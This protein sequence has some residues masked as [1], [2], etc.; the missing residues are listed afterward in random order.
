MR[1]SFPR[2]LREVS[3]ATRMPV[4]EPVIRMETPITSLLAR[5]RTGDSRALEELTPR[6]Y[7]ELRRLASARFRRE[8]EGHTL[9]PTAL[10]HEAFLRLCGDGNEINWQSRAH[11]LGIAARVMRQVLIQHAR[12]RKAEKRGSGRVM[13]S[14]D[15]VAVASAAAS[16]GAGADA[17]DLLEID[18]A[19]DRLTDLD[20]RKAS[21]VELRF[22]GGLTVPE[23][24]VELS[25]SAS[26]V[27]REMRMGL[28]W[29]RRELGSSAKL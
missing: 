26:T 12:T 5:W 27:E 9:Q 28:A 15:D 3:P 4:I 7:S 10:V 22:F 21:V 19:L 6:V 29:L 11:F 13:M 8:R 1:A 14:L 20:A 24:A 18:Q 25:I 16:A 17:G 2:A 23:I